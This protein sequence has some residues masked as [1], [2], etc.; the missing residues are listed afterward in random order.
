MS[1]PDIPFAVWALAALDPVLIAVAVYLG[2]KADQAGKIFV[3]AIAA[4]GVSLLVDWFLT[5]IGLPLLAPL[6][7]TGPM[8]LPVRS[9]AALAWAGAGY[10]ARR[11]L[12]PGTP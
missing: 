5:W 6:S 8:L 9:L 1:P 2:W 12:R 10:L 4:L 11:A 7:R 3:A